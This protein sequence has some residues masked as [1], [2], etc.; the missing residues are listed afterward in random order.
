MMLKKIKFYLLILILI[1]ILLF[2]YV[3]INSKTFYK[4]AIN[5]IKNNYDIIFN[6]KFDNELTGIL[7]TEHTTNLVHSNNKTY[8]KN[9]DFI[10]KKEDNKLYVYLDNKFSEIEINKYYDIFKI[11]NIDNCKYLNETNNKYNYSCDNYNL[12]IYTSKIFNDYI[13]SEIIY[14]DVVI[15]F[16]R[17]NI[18]YNNKNL[19]L[20]YSNI[21]KDNYVLNIEFENKNVKMFY[22]YNEYAKYS[23]LYDDLRFNVI[24]NDNIILSMN[25]NTKNYS[26]FKLTFNKEKIQIKDNYI[27]TN[28]D[29]ILSTILSSEIYELFD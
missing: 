27:Q 6:V 22:T 7:K 20:N 13:K 1:I 19:N 18:K 16:N 17:D 11:D 12:S 4:K 5:N 24:D 29:D 10:L 2:C 25:H 26:K 14:D 9:Y 21:K 28:I 8:E 15:E 23:F 3:F